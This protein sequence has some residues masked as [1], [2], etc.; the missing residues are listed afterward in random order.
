ME[1]QTVIVMFCD[2]TL[3]SSKYKPKPHEAV[4]ISAY[5]RTKDQD[6]QGYWHP[7][8]AVKF[9]GTDHIL[10]TNSTDQL[11][12][13][14]EL[15]LPDYSG[16]EQLPP[17]SPEAARVSIRQK[18]QDFWERYWL[19]PERLRQQTGGE[20]RSQYRWRCPQPNCYDLPV[21]DLAAVHRIFD[22]YAS[23]GEISLATVEDWLKKAKKAKKRR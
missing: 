17:N 16:V 9:R 22:M 1:R 13:D 18:T 6:G 7:I 11:V 12:G 14:V 21:N 3:G 20:R 23:A 19:E 10:E 8:Y 5:R 15:T 4:P 2:G